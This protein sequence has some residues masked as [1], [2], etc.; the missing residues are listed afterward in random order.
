MCADHGDAYGATCTRPHGVRHLFAAC[1]LGKDKL[2]GHIKPRR[3]R[4]RFLE[5]CRC[6]RGLH[7]WPRPTSPESE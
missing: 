3:H 1:D 2:Y 7:P 5:C 6:L 4:T